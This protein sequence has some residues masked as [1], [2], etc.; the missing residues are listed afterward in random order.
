MAP[1]TSL[2]YN[3]IMNKREAMSVSLSPGLSRYV[4]ARV[5]SG[6]Y[7]SVSEVVRESLRRMMDAESRREREHK[8]LVRSIREGVAAA[9]A[10][11]LVDADDLF[12]EIASR[13]RARRKKAA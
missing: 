3:V 11:K 7:Q 1:C 4:R 5:R 13:S 10:G 2:S 8:A 12:A 9:D 6:T